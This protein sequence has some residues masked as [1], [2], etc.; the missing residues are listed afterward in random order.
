MPGN[1]LE[2]IAIASSGSL[3]RY[4]RCRAPRADLNEALDGA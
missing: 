1:I 4:A 3:M 2:T